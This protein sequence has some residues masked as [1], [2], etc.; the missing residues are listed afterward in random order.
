MEGK[1]E[2]YSRFCFR[3]LLCSEFVSLLLKRRG[4]QVFL[5]RVVSHAVCTLWVDKNSAKQKM[6]ESKT[7]KSENLHPTKR[8]D[9]KQ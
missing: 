9:T 1:T 5:L 6:N 2:G 8:I 4:G 3:G 7:L